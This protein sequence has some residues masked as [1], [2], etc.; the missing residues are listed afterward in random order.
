[1]DTAKLAAYVGEQL[2]NRVAPKDIKEQLAA[3]GWLEDEADAALARGLAEAG[4]PVPE[5]KEVGGKKASV[6]EIAV[7][8]FSFVLL[9]AVAFALGALYF[10]IINRYFPDPLVDRTLYYQTNTL[11]K[12]IHYAIATLIIAYPL[13]YAAVRIWFRRFHAEVKKTE[14]R[15]TKWLTYIVLIA[16]AGTV[17]GDL[18]TALFTFFQGEITVR[19]FLKAVTVLIIGAMIFIFYFLERR[20]IQYGQAIERTVFA[21]LGSAVSAL[22]VVGI[23]LGFV[24]TG[25]PT[26]ARMVGFDMQRSQDLQS[27]SYAVQSFTRRFERL[28]ESLDELMQ[29]NGSYGPI[30]ALDPETGTPYE[31]R[32]VAQPLGTSAIREGT[33]ELCA[34]F[35]LV[36]ER[37]VTAYGTKYDAHDAGRSCFTEITSAK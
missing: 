4:V 1:M 24:A 35:S 11:A 23:I 28:P 17:V 32:V 12:V 29:A 19:F 13:Y 37:G 6:A 15:L 8:F 27:I 9:G 3:V 21:S 14:S 26:T 10:G 22:I 18:I 20:K 5:G 7:N 31:Y 16:A 36:A 2:R 33:Y 30:T 25:S 34:I